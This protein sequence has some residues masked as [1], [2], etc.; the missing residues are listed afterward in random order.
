MPRSMTY[1]SIAAGIALCQECDLHALRKKAVPGRGNLNADIFLLGE[2]PGKF[3]D[4]A[5]LPFVGKA[6]KLLTLQVLNDI[7]LCA[8]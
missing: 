8:I 7:I 6:G 5:G 4:I 3:E 1:S 2:A